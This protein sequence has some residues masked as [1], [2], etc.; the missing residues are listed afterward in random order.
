M[1]TP[2]RDNIMVCNSIKAQIDRP[3]KEINND[4]LLRPRLDDYYYD[5]TWLGRGSLSR[6]QWEIRQLYKTTTNK[7]L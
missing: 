5:V 2:E 1:S 7:T 6:I 4:A 3:R